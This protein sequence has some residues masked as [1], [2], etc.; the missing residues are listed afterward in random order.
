MF[1]FG[2]GHRDGI[3]ALLMGIGW[4]ITG[5]IAFLIWVGILI[6]LVRF[7]VIG[8]RAAKL[9]LS[10]NGQESRM[11]AKRPEPPAPSATPA[12]ASNSSSTASKPAAKRPA[13]SSTTKKPPPRS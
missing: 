9:Y 11:F 6:L 8:T 12:P 10:Q 7:L 2:Y 1:G 13:Q 3:W 4:T 5:F